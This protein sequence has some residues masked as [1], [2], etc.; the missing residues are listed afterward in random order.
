MTPELSKVKRE[1]LAYWRKLPSRS[2]KDFMQRKWD[3]VIRCRFC[4]VATLPLHF[5]VLYTEND[6]LRALSHAL[7]NDIEMKRVGSFTRGTAAGGGVDLDYQVHR[8]PNSKHAGEPFTQLDKQ[9][10]AQN[11]EKLEIVKGPVT[12]GNIAIKFKVGNVPAKKSIQRSMASQTLCIV[13][14]DLVLVSKPRPEE[15]PNLRGGKDFHENSER[16][17]RFYEQTPAA[18]YVILEVKKHCHVRPKGILLEAVV[19]G[20][21]ETYEGPLTTLTDSPQSGSTAVQTQLEMA[22]EGWS[23]LKYVLR[24]L[25][26]WEDSPF[27]SDLKK[28]LNMLPDRKREEHIQ[29]FGSFPSHT[30]DELMFDYLW[31]HVLIDAKASE[32]KGVPSPGHMR[33]KLWKFLEAPRRLRRRK[34]RH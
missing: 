3:E 30:V 27:G 6:L 21:S 11:L 9:K 33:S 23:F 31:D 14:V 29:S 13:N 7:G 22:R 1:G 12:I 5:F 16:I 20:L 24:M 10:V 34:Q 32:W 17:N 4:G 18:R 26:N 19:W 2:K 8:S 25:R 15:F 28:D